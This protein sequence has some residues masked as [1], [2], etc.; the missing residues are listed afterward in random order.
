MTRL[1]P[2]RTIALSCAVLGS[3]LLAGCGKGA[4]SAETR[5]FPLEA[6]RQWA[7]R[8]TTTFEDPN[9]KPLREELRID[10][11]GLDPIDGNDAWRR[12]AS[13]GMDYWIRVDNSGIYR[14]ASRTPLQAEPVTDE[15]VRYVLK[16]PYAVG[17]SWESSTTGYVLHRTNEVPKE[18]RR[19][20][21]PVPM[22]YTIAA[23]NEKVQ[24]PAGEFSDCIRVDGLAHV[25]IYV[26]AEFAWRDSPLYSHE[27]FCPD[28]G[29]VKS[30]RREASPTRFMMGGVVALELT[31]WR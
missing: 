23:T 17:T 28:V 11:R 16:K 21:K 19:F 13:A 3:A 31:Q 14:V 8:M 18:L 6:G 9:A 25:R 15:W 20:H 29:L 2:L 26:E 24:V 4:P 10:S 5:Y 12:H 30:E 7:Y 1:P 27:W 22:T